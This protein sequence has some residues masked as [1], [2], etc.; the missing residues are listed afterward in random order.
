VAGSAAANIW[1]T[2]LGLFTTPYI[3]LGLGSTAYGV[4][5]MVSMM[6]AHL[7][8]LELGF[9]HATVY[10]LVRARAAGDTEAERV[11]V[12][13]SGAVFLAGGLMG[14]ALLFSGAPYLVSSFFHIDPLLQWDAL[15]AFRIG[16][17]I[18]LCSFM[19][20]LFSAVLQAFGRFDWLNGS[21]AV[22]GTAAAAAAVA[23][24][25]AGGGLTAVFVAQATV[26][27]GSGLVLAAVVT[28]FRRG[29]M[30]FRIERKVLREMAPYAIVA[31][32][33]GI[34][35]QWMVNGPPL[36]LAAH[37]NAAEIPAFSVPHMVLQRLTVLINAG[38]TVF[39]PFVSG[40]SIGS[41]SSRLKLAFQSHVRLTILFM[42]PVVGFLVVFAP[43][44]L[45]A[46]VS[47]EF[48]R[49]ATPCLRLLAVAAL[50]LA[51]AGPPSDVARG[52]GRPGWVLAFTSSAAILGVVI[53]MVAVPSYG[54]RGAAFALCSSVLAS[55]VTLVV[56][57]A[58][59]FLG[60]RIRDLA[61]TLGGPAAAVAL[62]TA[63][64]AAGATIGAGLVGALVTGTL[65]TVVYAAAGFF[66]V[67]APRERE[68]LQQ[69]VVQA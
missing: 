63:G 25:A 37:V 7:S 6:S 41:D 9:G 5:A 68:A 1:L 16:A 36:V 44:L 59:R 29:T 45:G 46:W 69:V 33:G 55:T 15:T 60:L 10:Y 52:L 62:V 3:L 47:P 48:S 23:A 21:R 18:F 65:A 56:T 34:A 26:A 22:F 13:A 8:N 11:T 53:S 58:R 49:A 61:R 2:A 31:F 4:F 67:L 12:N 19:T 39:F 64:Y 38:S 40:S 30:R 54:A 50:F 28:R 51:I 66:L 35:Y 43:T 14:A 17:L 20:S 27:C 32:V 42:G 57:V 24:I